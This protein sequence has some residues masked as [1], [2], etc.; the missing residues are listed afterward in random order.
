M[1][2]FSIVFAVIVLGASPIWTAPQVQLTTG[3]VMFDA[4]PFVVDDALSVV[5]TSATLTSAVVTLW[6]FPDGPQES[7]SASASGAITGGDI[8]WS[9]PS[10][11]ITA[12]APVADYQAVLRSVVYVNAAGTPTAGLRRVQFRISDGSEAGQ[13]NVRAIGIDFAYGAGDSVINELHYDPLD[14]TTPW[15]FIEIY[16]AGAEAIDLSDWYF[17]NGVDYT[18]PSGAML[19]PGSYAVVAQDPDELLAQFGV[20]SYGPFTGKLSNDGEQVMLRDAAGFKRDEVTYQGN[21]PWPCGSHGGGQSM[22]LIRPD[23]DNDLAGNWRP[24]GGYIPYD[25]ISE[26]G[27]EDVTGGGDGVDGTASASSEYGAPW[28]ELAVNAFDND[29][30]T[31]WTTTGGFPQWLQFELDEAKSID[32]YS[33]E[34]RSAMT[35]RVP[36]DF[37]IEGS[38]DGSIW[39]VLDTVTGHSGTAKTIFSIPRTDA[40]KFYRIYITANN[41]DSLVDLAEMEFLSSV[42]E[43]ATPG[44]QN[45]VYTTSIPPRLRQVDHSPN[46]PEAS[47]PMV[48]TVK[49]TDPDGVASVTLHYQ[50]V[51]P[52]SYIRLSDAAYETTWTDVAMNDAGLDG[53]E[54]AGDDVFSVTLPGTIQTHRRLVRYRITAEDGVGDSITAPFP[55][56]PTPNFAYFVYNGVPEWSGAIN[57]GG[58]APEN[59]AVTFTTDTLTSL[60]VYHL[61]ATNADVL[62]CQ[63]TGPYA[64]GLYRYEGTLVYDGDVYDHVRFRIKGAAS[65]RVWGKNKWK[66]N[67]PR[68]NRFKARDNYGHRYNTLWDKLVVSTGTCPWWK[69]P[70]P[71]GF[72]DQGTGGMY[73]NEALGMRFFQLAGVP[74]SNTHYFH[75]R[76]IDD[77]VEA[78]PI[79][80]YEGDFWGMYLAI[81]QPDGRFLDEREL[82]D[83]N[84]YKNDGADSHYTNQGPA[85]VT[86]MSDYN[87][88]VSSSTGYNKTGPIQPLSWWQNN[89]NLDEYYRQNAVSMLI[90]NSDRRAEPAF[91]YLYYHHPETGLWWM[92]PWD[93]DLSFEYGGHY[94]FP[95]AD[96]EHWYYIIDTTA[97]YA[98]ERIK[99]ANVARELGDLLFNSDEG[100]RLIDEYFAFIYQ[101]GGQSFADADRAQWEFHPRVAAASGGKYLDAYFARNEYLTSQDWDGL[102]A[103][104]KQYITSAGFGSVYGG[105]KLAADAAD[106]DIPSTPA[107][108]YTGGA[109]YPLN[110]LSFE[111]SAFADPQGAGTFA[112]MK[113][114]IGEISVPGSPSFEPDEPQKYEVQAIWESEEITT[115]DNSILIPADGL[116]VAHIYRVRVKM[117]DATGRYSHWSEP[118]EFTAGDPDTQAQLALSLRVSE[119]MYNPPG[120]DDYEFIELY[121]SSESTAVEFNGEI[122][123]GGIDFTMPAGTLIP[124]GGYLLVSRDS[125]TDFANFR[126]HYGLDTSVPIVGPYSGK[127][128]NDGERVELSRNSGGAKLFAFEYNDSRGWPLPADGSGHSMVPVNIATQP[129][130]SLDYC[131][132]WRSSTY[133]DGSP[134]EADPTPPQTV[135][136][137]EVVAHTDV[138]APPYDSNDSIELLNTTDTVVNF[139]DWYLTDDPSVLDKWA[140]DNSQGSILAGQYLVLDEMNDFHNPITEGFGLSKSGEQLLLSYLPGTSEDRVVDW[141]RFKGQENGLSLSR[142]PDGDGYWRNT[143][144]TTGTANSAPLE[145]V[146]ISEIM[147]NADG[148]D[149][150]MEFIELYNLSSAPIELFEL[151]DAVNE[152]WQING[153]DTDYT[154]PAGITIAAGERIVLVNFDPS[155]VPDLAAFEAQYGAVTARMF[156]SLPDNLSNS[157]Q[158]VALERPQPADPPEIDPSWVIVDEVIYFDQAPWTPD[159]DGTGLSLNRVEDNGA[160]RNPQNW[161]AL[162][163]TPGEDLPSVNVAL[164]SLDVTPGG[165]IYSGTVEIRAT[166]AEAVSGFDASDWIT[167]GN[168]AVQPF[169]FYDAGDG[170]NYRI[171]VAHTGYGVMQIGIPA[172]AAVSTDGSARSNA[173]SNVFSYTYVAMPIEDSTK[174]SNWYLY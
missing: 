141:V 134:G 18:F 62:A 28:Y 75:F 5:A 128:S 81:E 10:L 69:Y 41:G 99:Y 174:V 48:I 136:L 52:G 68:T 97:G 65:T 124:P 123:T 77:A 84:V 61:I 4:S 8:V 70:H 111:C 27:D 158:R 14:K 104:Y 133:I 161:I 39:T 19:L 115:F 76:V 31:P 102:K 51:D 142:Y 116:E 15:E 34:S 110:D 172:G 79:D 23:L 126:A 132:N 86:D 169:S 162:T 140:I 130:N 29:T 165:T 85:Q 3:D 20:S 121:N 80:Q 58:S 44:A 90:N 152:P 103:Y 42:E 118:V 94:A 131:G 119:V 12:T 137:N 148:E 43:N 22:E 171:N 144:I 156:G 72:W 87:A 36:S 83:G 125:T 35:A 114:R 13:G 155:S 170:M 82:P 139:T 32:G 150:G 151:I 47:E 143:A 173:A 60:P 16:N 149:D 1:K 145:D 166:F 101:S 11:Q 147:Y 37:T 112:A 159:A 78:D 127:L 66:F 55:D 73:W 2:R 96:Q 120:D 30:G 106:A 91:N 9:S 46:E 164:S 33:L 93:L 122:F 74:A 53:D 105:G 26:S 138:N 17:S 167:T 100:A 163:P 6:D 95:P 88:F 109:G 168:L 24:S 63:Y 38:N 54:T 146:V 40:Y 25:S 57:P 59:V 49:A 153:F 98:G 117:K 71:D 67:F 92:I 64:D 113:W 135:V 160:G 7:L 154:L 45:S 108:T 56:D 50:P 129:E 89:I 107:I 21:F 157:V